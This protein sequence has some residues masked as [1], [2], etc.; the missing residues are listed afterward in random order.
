LIKA[1]ELGVPT[2]QQNTMPFAGQN[3]KRKIHDAHRFEDEQFKV[4]RGAR[5]YN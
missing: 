4:A 3:S 2:L 1:Q 5:L